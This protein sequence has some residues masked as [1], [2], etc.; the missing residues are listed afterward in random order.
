MNRVIMTRRKHGANAL[1]VSFS[2]MYCY[3]SQ[4]AFKQIRQRERFKRSS[5][6]SEWLQFSRI[7]RKMPFIYKHSAASKWQTVSA[8]K[9]KKVYV[10]YS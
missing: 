4:L 6:S 3:T 1:L 7:K 8:R 5:K 10:E 2:F 9:K